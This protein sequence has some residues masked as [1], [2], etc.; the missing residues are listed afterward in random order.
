MFWTVFLN[1]QRARDFAASGAVCRPALA[2]GV[3]GPWGSTG[4]SSP[5][6]FESLADNK[7]DRCGCNGQNWQRARDSNP[8]GCYALLAFQASS[9]A[10]RSTLCIMLCGKI[11][12]GV[13]CE[14]Y[15]LLYW[16]TPDFAIY[17]LRCQST[18]STVGRGNMGHHIVVFIMKIWE[19][20]FA[21]ETA[22]QGVLGTG[23]RAEQIVRYWIRQ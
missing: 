5:F 22:S 12:W 6:G 16:H 10:I 15:L 20:V 23:E 14:T 8:Q 9:L 11:S 3:L 13:F 4:A 17:I 2:I 21:N 1:W 18:W 19:N 7:K